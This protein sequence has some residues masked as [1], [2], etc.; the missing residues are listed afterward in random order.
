MNPKALLTYAKT[1]ADTFT[2]GGISS[3]SIRLFEYGG[4]RYVLKLPLMTGDRLSPFW[5]MMKNIL[6]FTFETQSERLEALCRRLAENPH[7]KTAPFLAADRD[8]MLYGFIEGTAGPDDRFPDAGDNAF[9][10]GQYIGFN[11]AV[12]HARCGMLGKEDVEDFFSAALR[13]MEACVRCHWTEDTPLDAAVRDFFAKLKTQRLESSRYSLIMGDMS[14]D[15]FLFDKD[16]RIVACV[17][18][19]AYVI[20]P[21]EWELSMLKTQVSD[22]ESFQKGYACYQNMP[23]FAAMQDFFYFLMALNAYNSKNELENDWAPLFTAPFLHT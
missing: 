13:H 6:G 16:G 21:V 23:D 14:A 2:Q 20:A 12:A 19:D 11:H 5:Q 15:Q 4:K 7:I 3:N 9:R 22:W 18:L 8:A 1:H 10:L 17:D